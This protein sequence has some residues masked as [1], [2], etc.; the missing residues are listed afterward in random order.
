L[1]KMRCA[2]QQVA[3]LDA[4]LELDSRAKTK[5][6]SLESPAVEFRRSVELFLGDV[7]RQ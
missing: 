2:S 4:F 6:V 5:N 3:A 1:G 7:L